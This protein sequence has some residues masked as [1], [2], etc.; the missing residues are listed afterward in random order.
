MSLDKGAPGKHPLARVGLFGTPFHGRVRGGSIT[1]PNSATRTYPQPDATWPDQAGTTHRLKRP[2]IPEVSRSLEQLE[3]DVAAGREW[4]NEAILAGYRQ[5]LYGQD[6]DGWIYID[7]AGDRWLV[8]ISADLGATTFSFASPLNL[9]L[10]FTRFGAFGQPASTHNYSITLSDWGQQGYPPLQGFRGED[11]SFETVSSAHLVVDGIYSDGSK[12][13]L[14]VHRRRLAG[15]HVSDTTA[16]VTVRHPLGWLQIAISGPGSAAGVGFSVLKDRDDAMA[17]IKQD[18]S[19]DRVPAT[20]PALISPG[21]V[22]NTSEGSY[23]FEFESVRLIGLWPDEASNGWTE[24]ALRYKHSGTNGAEMNTAGN[25]YT[26]AWWAEIH[27]SFALEVGGV[28]QYVIDSTKTEVQNTTFRYELQS[29]VGVVYEQVQ[30][31]TYGLVLD[32]AS[33]GITT[34][35]GVESFVPAP[36]I[37][38]REVIGPSFYATTNMTGPVFRQLWRNPMWTDIPA[39]QPYTISI[40]MVRLCSKVYCL[41]MHLLSGTV[42]D[43]IYFP[44]VSPSGS[45]GGKVARAFLPT[46]RLY[47]SWCPATG[48]LADLDT[49]P[50]CW[51]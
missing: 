35:P 19:D 4:R 6:L 17:I 44:R 40:D 46:E 26:L 36:N 28:E 21:V 1:L 50:V 8:R 15:E 10:V 45:V 16:D 20:F 9:D 24:I 25:V 32:G 29:G 30:A 49:A 3:A 7:P 2:G 39:P 13:A 38:T 51:V 47:A 31:R 11:G 18:I 42:D 14:C 5:Q 37:I 22:I 12:I 43:F 41:R 34:D 27:N 33:Y 48:A 23:S